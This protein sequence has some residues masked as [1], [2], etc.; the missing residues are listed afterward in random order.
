[1]F[2]KVLNDFKDT[3]HQHTY[4][5]G[6]DYPKEGYK[7]EEKRVAY[8]QS[9]NPEYRMRFLGEGKEQPLEDSSFDS[10]I[11]HVGG[12]W[13][14]LPNGEKVQGKEEANA[15]LSEMKKGDA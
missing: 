15:A 11:K 10:K 4:K 9:E 2:F 13:Y 8:L 5:V 6:D 3:Q 12:G 14:E 7:A 1:M